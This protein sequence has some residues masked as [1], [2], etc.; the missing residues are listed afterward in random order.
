MRNSRRII[1]PAICILTLALGACDRR[2]KGVLSDSEMVDVMTDLKLAESYTSAY[3][4][5]PSDSVGARLA[6]A[7]LRSHGVS[8]AEFDS[9]LSWYGRNFDEY[10]K[11][12][13]K[14]DRRLAR[15]QK[16]F[17]SEPVT[18]EKLDA[19]SVWPYSR[20]VLISALGNSDGLAFS[21][22][23]SD[24]K[25][26][27]QIRWQMRLSE[28]TP[29]KVLLGTEYTDGSMQFIT[30]NAMGN[31]RLEI[32]LPTDT[33]LSVKR[34]FGNLHVGR[35]N[36][37]L[38][39]DSISLVH[40]P[41]NADDRTSLTPGTRYRLPG[42]YDAVKARQKARADSLRKAAA[43]DSLVAPGITSSAGKAHSQQATIST[44]AEPM[45]APSRNAT[46]II[47]RR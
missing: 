29:A 11:L 31:R 5:A 3:G 45:S 40:L 1:L 37:P 10:Y 43:S 21:I 8:R 20:Q 23:G 46:R 35:S 44:V 4:G 15:R 30:R 34:V 38:F 27:E 26:G 36:M 28:D 32:T 41:L 39:I 6:D 7:V 9:T 18:S 16:D 2:P 12:Y 14:V 47:R 24:V 42:R 13:E 22:N 17:L 25:P 33:V 19:S